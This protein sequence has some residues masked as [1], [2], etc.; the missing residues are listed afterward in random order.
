MTTIPT[1]RPVPAAL[2]PDP[3]FEP[4]TRL[5]L[6]KNRQRIRVVELLATGTSGGAQEHVYNL[7]TRIDRARYDVSVLSLSNGPAVRRLERAGIT[8]CVLDEMSDADAI[9]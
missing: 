7:V 6:P 5:P 9:E 1:P 8:T 4:I 3:C 2:V